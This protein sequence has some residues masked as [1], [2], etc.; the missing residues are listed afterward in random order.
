MNVSAMKHSA[1]ERLPLAYRLLVALAACVALAA[2]PAGTRLDGNHVHVLVPKSWK[3]A[4][5]IADAMKKSLSGKPGVVGDA[6]AWGD[7][8]AGVTGLLLWIDLTEP[9]DGRVRDAET[10]FLGGVIKSLPR[11][12][13]HEQR[14]ETATHIISRGSSTNADSD[15]TTLATAVVDKQGLLHGYML[16]C[17]RTGDAAARA[18]SL[19]TCD[20]LMASFQLTWKDA[21]LKP[22]E[23]K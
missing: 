3:P 15:L 23:K 19:A 13:E 11:A 7:T 8:R 20:A 4:P 17:V 22:L 16:T 9:M 2:A 12:G 18:K 10:A 5:T 1:P 6:V 14:E 21:E